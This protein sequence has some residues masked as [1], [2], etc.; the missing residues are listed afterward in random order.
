MRIGQKLHERGKAVF[1]LG[2]LGRL[3]HLLHQLEDADDVA[4]LRWI[5]VRGREILREHQ[6]DRREQALGGVIEKRVLP[7]LGRVAVGVDDGLGKQLRVLLRLCAVRKVVRVCPRL[8]HV[9]VDERQQVVA[10]RARGIAEVDHGDVVAVVRLCHRAI[11]AREVAL[12]VEREEAHAAG[13]GVL[14]VR[15]EEE[16]RLAD[17]GRADHKDVDVVAVHQRRDVPAFLPHV[18]PALENTLTLAAEDHALRF[19]TRL[20][21]LPP[22]PG[23]ERDAP[24]APVDL[25]HGC[26]ARRA[27]LPVA[28]GAGLD[29]VERLLVADGEHDANEQTERGNG[30]HQGPHI[31]W[32]TCLTSCVWLCSTK[33]SFQSLRSETRRS[34]S[35]PCTASSAANRSLALWPALSLSRQ[36]K[37]VSTHGIR[38]SIFCTG[39]SDV[40]QHAT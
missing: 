31:V 24:E 35:T 25:V 11:V 33:S 23:A 1:L 28:H 6:H 32:H 15:V 18:A 26:P 21:I 36:R 13:A 10:I 5:G 40:P 4:A 34:V 14:Q 19:G 9:G 3:Q 30:N 7:V 38:S 8:I 22:E 29:A 16:R 20:Y 17:A 12:G 39:W 37:T 27:V 2:V